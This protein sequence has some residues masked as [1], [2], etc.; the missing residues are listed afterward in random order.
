MPQCREASRVGLGLH[1]G[2]LSDTE[3]GMFADFTYWI[4]HILLVY[5]KNLG[6]LISSKEQGRLTNASS[7]E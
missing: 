5:R 4:F 3:S 7:W 6:N 1:L 2:N